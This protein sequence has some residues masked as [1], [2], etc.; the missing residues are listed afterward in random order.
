[1][2]GDYIFSKTCSKQ[3]SSMFPLTCM[4][5]RG[6]F[7]SVWFCFTVEA[8]KHPTHSVCCSLFLFVLNRIKLFSMLFFTYIP[9]RFLPFIGQNWAISPSR[10]PSVSSDPVVSSHHGSCLGP[11]I[12]G[13]HLSPTAL[14]TG[15]EPSALRRKASGKLGVL[16]SGE[17]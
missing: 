17:A 4:E 7:V 2:L 11:W 5:P 9:L 14:E 6:P 1:M 12:F 15:A 13:L 16:L 10:K 3:F 8:G